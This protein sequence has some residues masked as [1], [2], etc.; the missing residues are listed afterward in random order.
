MFLQTAHIKS[1]TNKHDEIP[2]FH[3]AYGVVTF[4]AA[5]MFS[6]GT[7]GVLII[8]H[9]LLDVFKYRDVHKLSW[10]ITIRAV[11]HEN[12]LDIMLFLLAL[13]T[14]VYLHSSVE[15]I[16]FGAFLRTEISVVR[17]IAIVLPKFVILEHILKVFA[18]IHHY[19][20]YIHPGTYKKQF[21]LTEKI[22]SSII[23]SVLLLLLLTPQ[24]TGVD[25]EVIVHVVLYELQPFRL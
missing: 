2:A 13:V 23:V 22:Y 9:M 11:F 3:V 14:S 15:F 24:I 10:P 20:L 19:M 1:F 18:H 12:L 7:F 25:P 4:I 16:Q 17:L 6:I 5:A 21:T 8:A